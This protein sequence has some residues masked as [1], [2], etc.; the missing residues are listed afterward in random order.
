MRLQLRFEISHVV[1]VK[2]QGLDFVLGSQL[3]EALGDEGV[4]DRF[5]GRRMNVPILKPYF[6]RHA[7]DRGAI[8]QRVLRCP[9]LSDGLARLREVQV[10]RGQISLAGKVEAAIADLA[11]QLFPVKLGTAGQPGIDF[12]PWVRSVHPLAEI[13]PPNC[14]RLCRHALGIGDLLAQVLRL[15]R[16]P[17]RRVSLSPALLILERVVALVQGADEREEAVVE[18]PMPLRHALGTGRA[19]VDPELVVAVAN[20][21]AIVTTVGDH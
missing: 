3:A 9:E 13:Q 15:E 19:D 21:R 20:R 2:G 6:V 14:T 18:M 8:K 1:R 5:S 11:C 17:Q 4:V 12:Y 16:V 7:I 10:Q